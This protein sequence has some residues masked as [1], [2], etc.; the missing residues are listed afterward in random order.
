[1]GDH[2]SI[3]T[4]NKK[5]TESLKKGMFYSAESFVVVGFR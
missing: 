4:Q 2:I 1:M 5:L 3:C